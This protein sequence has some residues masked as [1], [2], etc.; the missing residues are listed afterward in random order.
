MASV[1]L[2]R[3]DLSRP[4]YTRRRSGKGFRYLDT[5]GSSLTDQDAIART[6]ATYRRVSAYMPFRRTP[7][8]P[9]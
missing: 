7:A 6:V 5:D 3:S 2:R 1:R 4:G 9:W 8:R